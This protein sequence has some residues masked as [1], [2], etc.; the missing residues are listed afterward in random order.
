MDTLDTPYLNK[1]VRNNILEKVNV[2]VWPLQLNHI[3]ISLLMIRICVRPRCP[4]SKQIITLKRLKMSYILG[5]KLCLDVHALVAFTYYATFVF[6]TQ[7]TMTKSGSQEKQE[8]YD[9][10]VNRVVEHPNR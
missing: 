1:I 10:F 4:K 7:L 3:L 8:L 2:K 5:F 9:P 6:R